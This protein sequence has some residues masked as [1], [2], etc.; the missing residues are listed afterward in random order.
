MALTDEDT[1]VVDR[2]CETEFVYAGLETTFQEILNLESKHV[3]KPDAG[4]VEDTDTDKTTNKSISF[5][6]ALG[7]FLIKGKK[8]TA[9]C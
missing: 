7:V 6:E 8:R 2:F 5:K 9:L 1:S 4:L 3:I